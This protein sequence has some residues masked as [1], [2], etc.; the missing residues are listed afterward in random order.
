MKLIVEN[1][2]LIF[3]P[4]T[5]SEKDQIKALG[6]VHE[7]ARNVGIFIHQPRPDFISF[8]AMVGPEN[9]VS[10]IL[11]GIVEVLHISGQNLEQAQTPGYTQVITKGPRDRFDPR[12]N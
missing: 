5:E 1:G 3:A 6:A 9:V 2:F 11:R 7:Q 8:Q 4:Q 12:S 10:E